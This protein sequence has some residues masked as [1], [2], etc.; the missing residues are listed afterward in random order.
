MKNYLTLAALVPT[1]LLVPARAD[2]GCPEWTRSGQSP[3]YPRSRFL[4]GLG[5]A[6]GMP[7]QAAGEVPAKTAALSDMSKQIVASISST[8]TVEASGSSSGGGHFSVQDKSTIK[9][10]IKLPDAQ[11]VARCFDPQQATMYALAAVDRAVAQQHISA[12]VDTAADK[13]SREMKA[14]NAALKKRAPMDALTHLQPA[15]EAI[16]EVETQLIVLRAIGGSYKGATPTRS[17]FKDLAHSL[18]SKLRVTV[19]AT[20]EGAKQVAASVVERLTKLGVEVQTAD[21]AAGAVVIKLEVSERALV[22]SVIAA[23]MAAQE[24]A[25][26]EV[27][28]LDTDAVI[29]GFQKEGRGVGR[30]ESDAR[31]RAFTNLAGLIGPAVE[32][33]LKGPLALG[34]EGE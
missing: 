19:I 11:I 23:G 29:A 33:S 24:A 12:A 6:G 8:T 32:N 20:G 27:K 13:A 3:E 16:D 22:P 14:I 31:S 17:D 25:D 18:R 15:R 2:A 9:S 26:V 28:R 4:V 10:A 30:A 21:R 5:V 34:A 1:L 7:S